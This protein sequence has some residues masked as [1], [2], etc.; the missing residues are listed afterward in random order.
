MI[1]KA[2]VHEEKSPPPDLTGTLTHLSPLPAETSHPLLPPLG[3]HAP[4]N[5]K[6][7]RHFVILFQ[8]ITGKGAPRKLDVAGNETDEMFGDVL[9]VLNHGF[10]SGDGGGAFDRVGGGSARGSCYNDLHF[11]Y[12][13]ITRLL[14][15]WKL[16]TNENK[17]GVSLQRFWRRITN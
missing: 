9:L 5:I 12:F 4:G 7:K 6:E 1:K 17:E 13:W 14:K 16:P 2:Q 8:S 10:E 3:S 15:T 11:E